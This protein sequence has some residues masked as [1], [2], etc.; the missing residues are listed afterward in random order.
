MTVQE[1]RA[2]LKEDIVETLHIEGITAGDIDDDMI[3]FSEEGLDLDS[4][5]AVELV[6]MLEK[7]Y[8]VVIEDSATARKV[9]VS[10]AVLADY[11][12]EV[13][14]AQSAGHGN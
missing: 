2:R 1:C 6:V 8:K 10:V 7:N 4:L 5:D 3:L 9:F 14:G 11:I 12:L 13:Q